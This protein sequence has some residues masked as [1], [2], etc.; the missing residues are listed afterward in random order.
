[1]KVPGGS[2]AFNLETPDIFNRA[3]LDFLRDASA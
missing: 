2:H 3:V 1:V